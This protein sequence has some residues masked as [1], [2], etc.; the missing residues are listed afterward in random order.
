MG[1]GTA[2][3]MVAGAPGGEALEASTSA[4][5]PAPVTCISTGVTGAEVT[6]AASVALLRDLLRGS[7]PPVPS[8]SDAAAMSTS[9]VFSPISITSPEEG[10]AK[11]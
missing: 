7:P 8:S 9:T 3:A 10:P 4:G 1:L 11:E 2:V 6:V 5:L